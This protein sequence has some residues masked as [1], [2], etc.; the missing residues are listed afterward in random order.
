MPTHFPAPPV[1][2]SIAGDIDELTG[3]FMTF[4]RATNARDR[5]LETYGIAI[6][7]LSNFLRS[8]GMPTEVA[9]IKVKVT[10]AR[11]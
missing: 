9:Q 6:S 7:Q 10:C 4:L 3:S 8:A 5:T 2:V 11:H 1:S